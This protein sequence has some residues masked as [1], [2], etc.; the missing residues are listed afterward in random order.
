MDCVFQIWADCWSGG[1]DVQWDFFEGL[2]YVPELSFYYYFDREFVLCYGFSVVDI[3]GVGVALR[4]FGMISYGQFS[5]F[6]LCLS[7]G[8][9]SDL[10]DVCVGNDVYNF[11]WVIDIFY[12]FYAFSVLFVTLELNMFGG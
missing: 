5:Y 3:R 7:W 11:E 1:R 2:D 8:Y 10:S 9:I 12:L 6:T 4:E